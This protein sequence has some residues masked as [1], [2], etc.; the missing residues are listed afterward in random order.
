MELKNTIFLFLR[1]AVLILIGLFGISIIY[2]ILTPLTAISSFLI[3]KIF[4]SASLGGSQIILGDF[5]INLVQACIAGAAYYLLLILNL[6]TPMQPLTRLKSLI[7]TLSFLF[8]LNVLRIVIFSAL[9]ISGFYYF[10][11]V[12]KLSWYVGSILLVIAIWFLNVALFKIKG[13]PAYTDLKNLFSAV[14]GRVNKKI[15]K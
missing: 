5:T 13:I 12:H 1:Y 10:D 2:T 11:A 7:F 8:I 15:K 4:Y 6:S 3:L 9:F 14:R